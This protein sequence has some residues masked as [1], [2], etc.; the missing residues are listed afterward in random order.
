MD[1]VAY[2]EHWVNGAGI[3]SL[4]ALAGARPHGAPTATA[5]S[6]PKLSQM[7]VPLARVRPALSLP[8]LDARSLEPIAHVLLHGSQATCDACAFSDVD[9]VAVVEDRRGFSAEQHARAARELRKLLHAVYRYDP[10]M[11]HGLMFFPASRLDAY[12]QSFLPLET[13]AL[14][15]PLH[16]PHEIALHPVPPDAQALRARVRNSANVLRTLVRG[17]AYERGD[18]AYKRFLSNV[19]LLPALIAAARGHF[20]Y[21]RKSFAIAHEWFTGAQWSAIERAE[22]LRASWTRP[23]PDAAQRIAARLGHPCLQVRWSSLR[24]SRE[25]AQR[26]PSAVSAMW[27]AELERT[28][29]RAEELAAA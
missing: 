20:V 3:H 9:V 25:N 22:A 19:L 6:P 7:H 5:G 11:H 4:A 8:A 10:L 2:Y 27:A 23:E 24:R 18:Y 12:D 15:Y 14:A 13:L 1:S 29:S 21:K 16:G 17:R 26:L 28:L